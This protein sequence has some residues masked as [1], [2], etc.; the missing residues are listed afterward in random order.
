ME[1]GRAFQARAL[2]EVPSKQQMVR[3]QMRLWFYVH[4]EVSME[5]D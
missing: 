5:S 4:V 3:G 2:P 1:P